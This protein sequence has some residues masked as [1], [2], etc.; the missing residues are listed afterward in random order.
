MMRRTIALVC[1][2]LV[3]AVA[4][5]AVS[6]GPARART[7]GQIIDDTA[8]VTAV[9]TKIAAERLSNLVNIDVKADRGVVTLGGT[10]DS[11]ERRDRIVQITSWVDGVKTVIN[12]IQ[13]SGSGAPTTSTVPPVNPPPPG[14]GARVDATGSVA[15]VEPTSGTLTLADGRV[16]R[17]GEGTVLWQASTLDALKPGTEVLI[18]NA[19]PAALRGRDASTPADWRMGTVSRVDRS[20]GQVVLTDGTLVRVTPSTVVQRGSERLAL[21]AL[22]PGWEIVVRTPPAPAVEAS[23]IDV[24]WPSASAR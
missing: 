20:A 12:N 24:V 2:L 11:L 21:D 19:A 14:A 15:A 10:V 18:R 7:I 16:L 1:V 9:K 17:M 3:V 6:A 23:Q 22:Q 4:I 5:V 13:V 8:L